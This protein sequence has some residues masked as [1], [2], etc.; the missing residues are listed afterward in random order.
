MPSKK[1]LKNRKNIKKPNVKKQK[2]GHIVPI[3][4]EALQYWTPLT[5]RTGRDCG[6]N[7]F[8]FL[9]YASRDLMEEM[10]RATHGILFPKPIF[11]LTNEFG[12][13]HS[14][15][16]I[17][18]NEVELD[19]DSIVRRILPVSYGTLAAF[20]NDEGNGHYASIA[21]DDNNNIVYLDPQT[22]EIYMNDEIDLLIRRE[23]WNSVYLYHQMDVFTNPE[24]YFT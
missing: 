24:K 14:M 2:G 5:C 1:T 13:P 12:I 3:T 19:T 8:A 18:S 7:T 10:G 22:N 20:I 9:R 21:I 17:Y 16:I 6:P 11:M 15:T 23:R 4:D